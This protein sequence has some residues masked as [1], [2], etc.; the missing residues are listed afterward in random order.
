MDFKAWRAHKEKLN[1]KYRSISVDIQ[2]LKVEQ[3]SPLVAK[4]S[5]KQTYKADDYQ[6]AGLKNLLL[7]KKGKSWKIKEEEWQPLD[8]GSRP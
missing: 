4:V 7:I 5:F 6:D 2:D 8:P 3:P 1:R